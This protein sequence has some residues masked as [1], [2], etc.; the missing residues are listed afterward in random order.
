MKKRLHRRTPFT[1]VLNGTSSAGKTS[2]V[3]ILLEKIKGSDI[4][5]LSIDTFVDMLPQRFVGKAN[6]ASRGFQFYPENGA[7]NIRVGDLGNL[8]IKQMHKVAKDLLLSGSSVVLDHVVL[9]E[10]WARTLYDLRKTG[11][12]II[13]VLITGDIHKLEKRE[14]ARSNRFIG[15]AKGLKHVEGKIENYDLVIDTTLHSPNK[16][17][18]MI[19]EYLM[20]FQ[21]LKS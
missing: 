20:Q 2:I 16:A 9:T 12:N 21:I 10:S 6:E 3:N 11:A 1:L 15:L 14:K 18:K 7:L 13:Y 17:A 19:L 8:I 4:F 5:A